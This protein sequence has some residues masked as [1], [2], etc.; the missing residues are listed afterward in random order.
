MSIFEPLTTSSYVLILIAK[1][2][3]NVPVHV[4]DTVEALP[5]SVEEVFSTPGVAVVGVAV[6]QPQDLVVC[7]GPDQ[8]GQPGGGEHSKVRL[9]DVETRS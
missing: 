6:A 9:Q 1:V 7:C 8:F 4:E 2:K 3:L 5:V